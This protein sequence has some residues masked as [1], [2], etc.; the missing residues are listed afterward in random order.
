[1]YSVVPALTHTTDPSEWD[2]ALDRSLPGPGCDALPLLGQLFHLMGRGV[3]FSAAPL[4]PLLRSGAERSLSC[5]LG[6]WDVLGS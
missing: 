1:M 6:A 3:W 2:S 4:A 5:L